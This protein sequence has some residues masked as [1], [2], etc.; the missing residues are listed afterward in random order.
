M[1]VEGEIVLTGL[2][3]TKKALKAYAPEVLKEMNAEIKGVGKSVA[4]LAKARIPEAP[5]M[6]GWRTVPATNG[7]SRGG[8]GWPAWS[9]S[10]MKKGIKFKTGGARRKKGSTTSDAYSLI[11]QSAAGMIFEL[12]G[13]SSNG[14][15]SGVA[16]INDLNHVRKASRAIYS[17]LDERGKK[18]VA[19]AI[20]QAVDKAEKALQATLNA[21]NDRE[22]GGI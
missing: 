3:D 15:G 5:P 4:T 16:L 19:E 1:P 18:E 7:R 21:A 12:A 22:V 10:E 6:R 14:A 9:P 8:A 17:A 13:R 20:V 11:N 2:K